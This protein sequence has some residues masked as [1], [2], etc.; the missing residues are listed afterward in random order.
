M[1]EKCGP[2][3]PQPPFSLHHPLLCLLVL[4][5]HLG[6]SSRLGVGEW[7]ACWPLLFPCRSTVC[8]SHAASKSLHPICLLGPLPWTLG[9]FWTLPWP[10]VS[11][12]HCCL[13]FCP[14]QLSH[15]WNRPWILEPPA[16]HCGSRQESGPNYTG[17]TEAFSPLAASMW[18]SRDSGFLR[19]CLWG[20][21]M[22]LPVSK[23]WPQEAENR[24]AWVYACFCPFHFNR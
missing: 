10:S 19:N 20:Q 16:L 18:Q 15:P 4:S 14:L 9:E 22:L 21:V 17:P 1:L 8:I 6:N 2:W 13:I 11:L 23:L 24:M 7:H 3:S 5:A 12:P